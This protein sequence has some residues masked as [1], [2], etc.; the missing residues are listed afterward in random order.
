MGSQVVRLPP[1]Q[2]QWNAPYPGNC[3]P[4][5]PYP[6][7]PPAC[8]PLFGPIVGVTDGSDAPAGMVGEF[9]SGSSGNLNYAAYPTV[10]NVVASTLVVPPGDWHMWAIA[11]VS[12]QTDGVTFFLDPL[13]VGVS[14]YMTGS[15]D[16]AGG[17]A[18]AGN[19]TVIGVHARGSFSVPTLLAFRFIVDQSGQSGL[20]AGYGYVSANARRM[21]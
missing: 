9:I 13:P 4:C 16:V 19:Y 21:R 17:N 6:C 1:A 15:V 20:P 3:Q 14:N 5:P 18:V 10:T 2:W 7:P 8:P 12:T 11:Q